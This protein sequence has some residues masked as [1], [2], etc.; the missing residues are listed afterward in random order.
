MNLY[1]RVKELCSERGI[2]IRQ[3]E[4]RLGIGNGIIA[5]WK[6]SI[7]NSERLDKVAD[8]F[9]V[10]TDYLLGKKPKEDFI[11]FY[12]KDVARMAQEIKDRPELIVYS[13][14]KKVGGI[15]PPNNITVATTRKE[16]CVE[17]AH[18]YYSI[19]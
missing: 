8:F 15:S 4:I 14:I 3:L 6:T 10:S 9:G 11:T 5:R 2:S 16:F 13:G 7:P 17:I 1:D 12:D 19:L 18:I